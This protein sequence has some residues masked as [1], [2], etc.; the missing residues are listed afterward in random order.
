MTGG[1]EKVLELYPLMRDGKLPFQ[2]IED[3]L[4]R[5]FDRL[6]DVE[7]QLVYWL[8]IDREPITLCQLRAHLLPDPHIDGEIFNALQSLLR[9]RIVIRQEQL[10]TL[11][12]VTIAYVTRRAIERL[13]IE[14]SPGVATSTGLQQQF[15]HLNTYAIICATAKDHLHQAQ[16]RTMLQPLCDRLLTIWLDRSALTHHLQQISIRWQTLVPPPPGYLVGNVLDLIIELTPDR[17]LYDLDY[18]KHV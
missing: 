3:V 18:G 4:A 9:R 12:P 14:L 6:S 5:Q 16:R 15:H 11:Q 1:G 2:G 17:S 8:A 7:Q 10:W 13:T